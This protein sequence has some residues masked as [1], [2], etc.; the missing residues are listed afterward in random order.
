MNTKRYYRYDF[1]LLILTVFLPVTILV[2]GTEWLAER[3]I[4]FVARTAVA[5]QFPPFGPQN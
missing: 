3:L 1:W 4:R 5:E 2:L